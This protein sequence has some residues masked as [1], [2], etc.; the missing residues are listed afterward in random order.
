MTTLVKGTEL[1]LTY[2]KSHIKC[3]KDDKKQL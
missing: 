2:T 3:E 1:H